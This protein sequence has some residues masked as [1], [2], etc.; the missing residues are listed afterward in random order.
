MPW[1]SNEIKTAIRFGF[2]GGANTFIGITAIMLI[3]LVSGR[4][5]LANIFGFA[6]G[7]I[8]GYFIH[9]K[10]TFSVSTSS[11]SLARYISVLVLGYVLNLVALRIIIRHT[12]SYAAQA[13]SVF[14]YICYSY[15]ATKRVV[16]KV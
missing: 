3:Q 10:K 2:W 1:M 14:I 9:A 11:S 6:I 15:I 13:L 5:Y 7:G 4:P 16:F 8:T 12:N